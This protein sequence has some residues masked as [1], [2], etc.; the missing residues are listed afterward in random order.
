MRTSPLLLGLLA[1]CVHES[2]YPLCDPLG[3][4]ACGNIGQVG[5]AAPPLQRAVVMARIAVVPPTPPEHPAPPRS[6]P[7]PTQVLLGASATQQLSHPIQR[8]L[9]NREEIVC[10]NVYGKGRYSGRR[11]CR[12][13]DGNLVS[14]TPHVVAEED[15]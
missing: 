12:D 9:M 1:A 13:P 8:P 15:E 5:R 10:G 7:A 2:A 4:P 3:A 14:S 11:E 6:E